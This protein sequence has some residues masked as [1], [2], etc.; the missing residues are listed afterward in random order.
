MDWCWPSPS[1][2]AELRFW[3]KRQADLVPQI[4]TAATNTEAQGCIS[5]LKVS[6]SIKKIL[7][8]SNI[9][10]VPQEGPLAELL[11][12][13]LALCPIALMPLYGITPP[14]EIMKF[15]LSHFSCLLRSLQTLTPSTPNNFLSCE[16][17]ERVLHPFVQVFSEEFAQFQSL[18]DAG[19]TTCQQ[20][21]AWS[22]HFSRH[23]TVYLR[24]AASW[25]T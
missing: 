10:L 1:W 8:F 23:L 7:E 24:S 25:D 9:K 3:N 18:M 13:Q 15:L 11:F 17:P 12:S 2:W 6:W 16:L 20:D 21:S 4:R 22:S 19:V 5:S 14:R